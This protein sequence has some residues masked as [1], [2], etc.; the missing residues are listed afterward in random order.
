MTKGWTK[1]E[2]SEIQAEALADW[3]E[4]NVPDS[5]V[6]RVLKSKSTLIAWFYH[7]GQPRYGFWHSQSQVIVIWQP[8][9]EGFESELKS[10]FPHEVGNEYFGRQTGFQPV[11]WEVR[12]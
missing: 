1:E 5:A 7:V 3:E 8:E 12:E 11:R 4:R 2:A 10:C 9:E 6:E